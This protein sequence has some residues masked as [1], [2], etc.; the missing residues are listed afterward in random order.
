MPAT[1]EHLVGREQVI[2]LQRDYP[3]PWGD[4]RVLR[5]VSDGV[6]T[7]AEIEIVGPA[8][9][10]RCAALWTIREDLLDDGVEYWVTVGSDRPPPDRPAYRP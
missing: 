3:E 8:D 10:F 2:A 9:L 7:V 1:D 6:V 5:V 4:L